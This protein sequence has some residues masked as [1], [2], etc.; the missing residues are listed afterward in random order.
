M[1]NITNFVITGTASVLLGL[2]SML[3][4][5]AVQ[6]GGQAPEA[7]VCNNKDNPP[8]D[9]VTQG[10]CI[11][12]NRAKGNCM[13]CHQIAGT[14]SGNISTKFENM[15]QRWPD[16]AKL[17]EQIFDASRANP[18]TIMPPFGR[19]QILTSEEIDKVVEFILSL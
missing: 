10:G 8:K 5:P 12:L 7:K 6:A 19:H 2:G 1:Q 3:T 18:R 11:V 14:S 13:G 17:R 9:V 4:V 15:A 16:K